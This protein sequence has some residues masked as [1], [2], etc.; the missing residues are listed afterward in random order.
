MQRFRSALPWVLTLFVYFLLVVIF[1]ASYKFCDCL[2][3]KNMEWGK[4]IYLSIVTITTLGYG[5]ITPDN[6]VGYFLTT[7]ET[8]LGITIFGWLLHKYTTYHSDRKE[9][10]KQ[11]RRIEQL[12]SSYLSFREYVASYCAEAIKFA[13]KDTKNSPAAFDMQSF[14][15]YLE[16][17]DN[18]KLLH[19]ALV[20]IPK[21]RTMITNEY[22]IFTRKIELTCLTISL[23]DKELLDF[24][25]KNISL[26]TRLEGAR[27]VASIQSDEQDRISAEMANILFDILIAIMAGLEKNGVKHSHDDFLVKINSLKS[28]IWKS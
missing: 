6:T 17:N 14:R 9:K 18:F 5:D 26:S 25:Y 22:K 2:N 16:R 10:I 21:L 13:S 19:H 20:D 27:A 11:E 3:D 8:L 24:F 1:A 12:E 4:S 28:Q 7:F 15:A 23:H